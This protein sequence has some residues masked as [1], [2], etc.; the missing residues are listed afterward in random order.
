MGRATAARRR[1]TAQSRARIRVS[2]AS[3]WLATAWRRQSRRVSRRPR[4]RAARTRVSN[5]S[6]AARRGA[7][8]PRPTFQDGFERAVADRREDRRADAP[9]SKHPVLADASR[10]HPVPAPARADRL[11]DVRAD[12]GRA[13]RRRG[14]RA[15]DDAGNPRRSRR[16]AGTCPCRPQETRHPATS[17]APSRRAGRRSTRS[18][19]RRSRKHP[20]RADVSPTAFPSSARRSEDAWTRRTAVDADSWPTPTLT[21]ASCRRRPRRPSRRRCRRARQLQDGAAGARV[22]ADAQAAA[23]AGGR[24][25]P[26][27]HRSRRTLPRRSCRTTR[28]PRRRRAAAPRKPPKVTTDD[29]ATIASELARRARRRVR[30][31]R[32]RV[33]VH[34]ATT[35]TR[36]A[37]R[38]SPTPKHAAYA[39]AGRRVRHV[40]AAGGRRDQRGPRSIFVAAADTR[41][42]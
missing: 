16:S 10:R 21:A 17:R 42:S 12:D 41:A 37:G 40:L 26:R 4:S 39:I 1:T 2:S 34:A 35:R 28:R 15:D 23:A 9:A 36:S 6:T 13:A 20:A 18:P 5:A 14:E 29:A 25:R 24:R 19:R 8:S 32:A 31:R 3:E 27:R 22:R 38:T 30:R 33:R 11:S 7:P